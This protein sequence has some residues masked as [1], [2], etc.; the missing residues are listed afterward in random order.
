MCFCLKIRVE[1]YSEDKQAPEFY[2]VYYTLSNLTIQPC[3]SFV[4]M[5][6]IRLRLSSEPNPFTVCACVCVCVL[7]WCIIELCLPGTCQRHLHFIGEHQTGLIRLNMAH[8]KEQTHA[9]TSRIRVSLVLFCSVC[10]NYRDVMWH[11]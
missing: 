2:D 10:L 6:M 4:I 5:G 7:N 8:L 3:D 9:H 1:L 11:W